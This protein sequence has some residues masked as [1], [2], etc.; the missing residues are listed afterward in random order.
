MT[1]TTPPCPRYGSRWFEI[2]ERDLDFPL[3][4][5]G[6]PHSAMRTW[7]IPAA[8]ITAI[9]V[10]PQ[11]S[12]GERIFLHVRGMKRPMPVCKSADYLRAELGLAGCVLCGM[13]AAAGSCSCNS[14]REQP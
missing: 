12:R 14:C 13:P 8:S 11:S 3:D 10:E 5:D 9:S 7:L 1:E 4:H 2:E 6:A